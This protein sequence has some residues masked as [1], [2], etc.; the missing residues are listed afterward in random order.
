MLTQRMGAAIQ[1]LRASVWMQPHQAG[2]EAVLW[3]DPPR[4]AICHRLKEW[5]NTQW[6]CPA[7]DGNAEE[8]HAD[9]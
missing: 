3:L 1:D 6:V 2:V 4:C 5:H 8:S 9:S 7:D